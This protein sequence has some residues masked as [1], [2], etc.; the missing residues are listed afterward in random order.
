MYIHIYT[1]IHTYKY[2]YI[3]R[4]LTF[5]R[6]GYPV[7]LYVGVEGPGVADGVRPCCTFGYTNYCVRIN[8][9]ARVPEGTP[10]FDM[11]CKSP[12]VKVSHD[13]LTSTCT[14]YLNAHTARGTSG[15]SSGI[16]YFEVRVNYIKLGGYLALCLGAHD[17]HTNTAIYPVA[18]YNAFVYTSQVCVCVCM[19]VCMY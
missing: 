14:S 6:N 3:Y 18:H 1:Y 13:H 16:V 17:L 11:I 15:F 7:G 5:F 19:Y 9:C 10:R 12:D 2:T 4:S 8:P